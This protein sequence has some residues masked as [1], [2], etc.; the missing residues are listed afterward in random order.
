[1]DSTPVKRVTRASR[2][3]SQ[4]DSTATLE[5]GP[6][7][8][9][10]ATKETAAAATIQPAME[11]KE[12]C[13]MM[14][15][16]CLHKASKEN[17]AG[18]YKQPPLGGEGLFSSCAPSET[19][20][21]LPSLRWA[22]S[23]EVWAQMRQQDVVKSAPEADLQVRHPG[24][25]PSM[26]V[27]LL[28]WMLEVCEEYRLHRETYYLAKDMLD[29]FLDTRSG[30]QKEQLQLI[31]V[32]CLFISA[33][34]E[35]IYPPKVGEFAYV[36]DGACSVASITEMELIICKTLRWRLNHSQVTVNTWVNTYVQLLSHHLRPGVKEREFELPAFSPIEFIKVMQL[37]DLCTLDTNSRQFGSSVLAASAFFLSSERSRAHLLLI[38]GYELSEI[39]L[40]VGW[41]HPFAVV[42]GHNGT[43]IQKAFSGVIPQDT[44][45]IQ[46]H[47]ISISMMDDARELGTTEEY[48]RMGYYESSVFLT[49]PRSERRCLAPINSPH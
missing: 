11:M 28:D 41:M 46:T 35:E 22:A 47:D 6:S 8:K 40:C 24:I 31:G 44:H 32:T 23:G 37:L 1:M 49:P 15:V 16:L 10:Q 2:K 39:R 27:I 25:V 14:S 43:I 30:L 38:T 13:M 42:Y 33:K 36:T 20:S 18:Y 21:P 29:R 3:R 4:E 9:R 7:R 48:L 34:I 17:P 45:N 5:Q 26:R 12:N 19:R